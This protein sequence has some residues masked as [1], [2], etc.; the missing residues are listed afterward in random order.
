MNESNYNKCK[1]LS[2]KVIVV[3]DIGVGKT[4]LISRYVFDK[5]TD[6]YKATL[7]VDFSHK[8]IQWDQDTIITI[9]LWDI[10]GQ[11]RYGPLM[12]N[13]YSNAVAALVVFDVTDKRTLQKAVKWKADI[14]DLVRLPENGS[15]AEPHAGASVPCFLI[16]NKKDILDEDTGINETEMKILC[17]D[18]KFTNCSFTSAKTFEGVSETMAEVIKQ[19]MSMNPLSREEYEPLSSDDGV[20]NLVERM[21][22]DNGNRSY[23]QQNSCCFSSIPSKEENS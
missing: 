4:S 15:F 17:R 5:F 23:D 2:F 12:R 18:H 22:S 16:G 21:R 11:E 1:S 8:K 20:I 6:G 9:Q 10:C 14:D 19:V 3:G 7:G 13:F